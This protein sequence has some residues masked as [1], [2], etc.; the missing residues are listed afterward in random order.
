MFFAFRGM[1]ARNVLPMVGLVPESPFP[2]TLV[3]GV[4]SVLWWL[5]FAEPDK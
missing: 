2:S 3:C 5:H 1:L 4:G